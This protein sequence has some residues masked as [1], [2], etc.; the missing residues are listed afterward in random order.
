MLNEC[1]ESFHSLAR[2][3]PVPLHDFLFLHIHS[4]CD[5]FPALSRSLFSICFL[6]TRRENSAKFWQL[7]LFIFENFS[8]C[9]SLVRHLL[10]LLPPLRL[11]MSMCSYKTVIKSSFMS[12]HDYVTILFFLLI[13]FSPRFFLLFFAAQ[14]TFNISHDDWKRFSQI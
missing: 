10:L 11:F 1:A 4:F 9:T 13:L 2:D 8:V 5:D 7:F 12:P 6:T 14:F 3:L